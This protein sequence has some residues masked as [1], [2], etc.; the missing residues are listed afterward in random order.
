[1]KNNTCNVDW[2]FSTNYLNCIAIISNHQTGYLTNNQEVRKALISLE[3][4][5]EIKTNVGHDTYYIYEDSTKLVQTLD[6]WQE[7]FDNNKCSYTYLNAIKKLEDTYQKDRAYDLRDS[8]LI[9]LYKTDEF[10]RETVN[11]NIYQFPS[12]FPKNHDLDD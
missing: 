3:V 9:E 7:W 12:L 11:L 4:L 10:Y 6:K 2:Q 1:V 5:T 8:F